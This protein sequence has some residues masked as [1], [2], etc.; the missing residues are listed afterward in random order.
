MN[1]RDRIPAS[2]QEQALARM[3]Q[4]S[5]AETLKPY[6]TQRLAK[7]GSTKAVSL[8]STA[9]V[10]ASGLVYAISTTE[11]ARPSSATSEHQEKNAKPE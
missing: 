2:Q 7:D 10:N 9:L 5:Q 4:L 8:T 6:Q 1:V 11:R 3:Y